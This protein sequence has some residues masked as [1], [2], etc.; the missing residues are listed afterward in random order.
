MLTASCTVASAVFFSHWRPVNQSVSV[1]SPL[2]SNRARSQ[3]VP[4]PLAFVCSLDQV[5]AYFVT[6]LPAATRPDSTL[7]WYHFTMLFC[8]QLANVPAAFA[9]SA[10]H[11]SSNG[12]T[13]ACVAPTVTIRTAPPIAAAEQF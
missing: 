12:S 4:V 11:F 10:W 8:T 3:V 2:S 7:I 6:H 5:A 1:P 13:L 9:R